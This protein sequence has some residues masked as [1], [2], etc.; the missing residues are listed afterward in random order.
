MKCTQC[1]SEQKATF[2][3][4]QSGI[5]CTCSYKATSQVSLQKYFRAAGVMSATG[6]VMTAH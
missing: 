4:L 3:N 2:R 1:K 6:N 5:V